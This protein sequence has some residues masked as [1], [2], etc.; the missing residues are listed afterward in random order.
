MSR[1]SMTTIEIKGL[2]I[3]KSRFIFWKLTPTAV[4]NK[5]KESI[6]LD[7]Q[8][9]N[10]GKVTVTPYYLKLESSERLSITTAQRTH[11]PASKGVKQKN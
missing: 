1:N 11:W 6:G 5:I 2:F 8:S 9:T 7:T 10:I 4:Q 3:L